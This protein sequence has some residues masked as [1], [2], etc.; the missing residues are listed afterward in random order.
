MREQ[1]SK[2]APLLLGDVF[3][4]RHQSHLQLD[5]IHVRRKPN[6]NVVM[7]FRSYNVLGSFEAKTFLKLHVK[8]EEKS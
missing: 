7:T 6:V 5:Y 2:D 1:A 4:S 3:H 8:E